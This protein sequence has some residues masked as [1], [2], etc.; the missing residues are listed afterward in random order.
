[1][2]AHHKAPGSIALL[3]VAMSALFSLAMFRGLEHSAG[4]GGSVYQ[5]LHPGSFPGD[6]F[7]S[8]FRPTMVSAYYLLVKLVGDVWLD[9]RFTIV[10]FAALAVLALAGVDKTVQLLGGRRTGE[11]VA[12]LSLI[13]VAH[14]V[15]DNQAQLLGSEFNATLFSSPLNIWLLYWCLA[16]PRPLVV[17]PLMVLILSLSV[18][19]GWLPCLITG[20]LLW[21]ERLR[22]RGQVIA[23]AATGLLG[24]LA[25]LG[26]AAFLRR[27][28]GT[29]VALFDYLH[30]ELENAEADPF[31]N[32]L[33]A[34]LVFV[35]LCLA[36][37]MVKGLPD[38]VS[39]RL[40]IL[41]GTGLAVWLAGGLYLSSAPDPIKIPYLV[42]LDVTRALWWIQYVMGAALGVALLKWLQRTASSAGVCVAWGLLMGLYL[43]HETFRAK[44]AAVV[45]VVTLVMVGMAW[46]RNVSD[47]LRPVVSPREKCLARFA[48]LPG[49]LSARTRLRIVAVAMCLGTLSLYSVGIV[50]RRWD[51]L[52]FLVRHGIVG[53][54]SGAIWVEV[55][56][57]IREHTPASATVFALASRNA[58]GEPWG[59][60]YE[61][62]L[63]N[64][65]GRS[66][67]LGSASAF[68]VDYQ[69]VQW[70]KAQRRHVQL[71]VEAWELQD[72]AGVS[73]HLAALGS[74]DYL[75]VPI[76][77]SAWLRE[78]PDFGYQFETA[79]GAYGI[80]R[81]RS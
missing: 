17:I 79:R 23:V 75:V 69:D 61:G 47:T 77:E 10:V 4:Y 2:S 80:F 63:R 11:R 24:V 76:E 39:V 51:A 21:K 71:V 29:D 8:L 7:M 26:Y 73:T 49:V 44:L 41:A 57:Y 66:M 74:P 6:R 16:G 52:A 50:H 13:F 68:Y 35:G 22:P 59:L 33:A 14:R 20:V 27:P 34:N 40:R 67:P 81:R 48:G 36:G 42:P 58:L 32:P 25:W 31:L 72:L 3:I 15:L 70:L 19:N 12:M 53:D 9:D 30:R 43:V 5:V 64:R 65:T 1:M 60:R 45:A 62:S 28:D 55:N 46:R 18:K 56:P 37:M 78:Q 38:A 54:N